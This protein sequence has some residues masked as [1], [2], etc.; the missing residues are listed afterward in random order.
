MN[1][2]SNKFNKETSSENEILNSALDLAMDFGENWLKPIND[3][4]LSKY[5]FLT[6][7]Q[8]NNYDL[9]ARAAMNKGHKFIYDTLLKAEDD[10]TRIFEKQLNEDFISFIKS[11][12]PW[13]NESNIRKMYNQGKY[14]AWRDGLNS[15]SPNL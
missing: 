8:L 7:D 1:F 12:E 14:Y 4:L 6:Q 5:K 2:F 11:E 9:V 10:T 15:V 13:I 3:R